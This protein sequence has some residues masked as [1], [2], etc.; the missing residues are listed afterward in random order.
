MNNQGTI[1]KSSGREYCGF[2]SEQ[3]FRFLAGAPSDWD[4][5]RDRLGEYDMSGIQ[6]TG[7]C[8]VKIPKG[9]FAVPG[10]PGIHT[11]DGNA[12]YCRIANPEFVTAPVKDYDFDIYSATT[13][14]NT[15]TC[16]V[17]I[18][19]GFFNVKNMPGIYWSNGVDAY[20]WIPAPK[21]VSGP[22]HEYISDV[23]SLSNMR[24]DGACPGMN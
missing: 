19:T 14:T 10:L 7:P 20:C 11:S 9:N 15:G 5:A 1:F 12:S 22:V 3:H 2:A 17:I 16:N 24:K 4:R 6:Y 8:K 13:M 18:P 23:Y 21:Y